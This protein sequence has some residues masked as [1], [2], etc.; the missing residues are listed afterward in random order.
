MKNLSVFTITLLFLSLT[1]APAEL[2]VGSY[3]LRTNV[4]RDLPFNGWKQRA[5]RCLEVLKAEK[6]DI[7]GT[8]ETQKCHIDTI[9]SI[10]YKAI[11]LP[12]ENK[13]NAEYS[14]IFY[15]PEILEL[16]KTE[17]FWLSETPDVTGSKSWNTA[18]P[19]ICTVGYF[20]HKASGKKFIYVNTHLDHKSRLA[21]EKGIELI[22]KYLKKFKL[23]YPYILTGDFN[24]RPDSEVYKKISGF[25]SDARHISEKTLPGAKQTYHAYRADPAKRRMSVPIDYIFV[26]DNAV[27]VKTFQVIDD[28][29]NG[30]ASSDHFPVA[31]TIVLK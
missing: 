9:T 15:N 21:R 26:N 11:G 1:A 3:N 19:R 28:F 22:I 18:C 2:K 16:E 25:M 7:F 12:R 31:A 6:F 24:A 5:P 27:K 20:T 14:T 4:P 30:F 29:K 23:D 8:Q 13:N 17:T 10:G